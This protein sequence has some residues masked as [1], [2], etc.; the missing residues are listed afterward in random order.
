MLRGAGFVA[1]FVALTIASRAEEV[2]LEQKLDEESTYTV[3]TSVKIDQK[4]SIAGTEW[5]LY[6]AT[7]EMALSTPAERGAVLRELTRGY[8][9]EFTP[10]A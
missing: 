6:V 4:L 1:I 10:L 2:R 5:N 3:D 7:H 9:P 8:R